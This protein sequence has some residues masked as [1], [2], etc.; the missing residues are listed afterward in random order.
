MKNQRLN[1]LG[2]KVNSMGLTE[3][4]FSN[5]E[6]KQQFVEGPITVE[7]LM[8]GIDLYAC[9]DTE[10]TIDTLN[11][12]ISYGKDS[13]GNDIRQHIFGNCFFAAVDE[14]GKTVELSKEQLATLI[15]HSRYGYLKANGN[16][17]MHIDMSAFF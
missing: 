2:R 9:D 7:R 3:Y 12:I 1:V 13:D 10:I 4:H 6:E 16:R 11:V 15:E 8:N 5:L 14:N 17:I